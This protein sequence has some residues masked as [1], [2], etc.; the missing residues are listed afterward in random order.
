MVQEAVVSDL[1]LSDYQPVGI[2]L[3]RSSNG[4]HKV[5]TYRDMASINFFD[6]NN[7]LERMV[8]SLSFCHL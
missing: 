5:I 8:G 6:F 3:A 4:T 1:A 7:D 2:T